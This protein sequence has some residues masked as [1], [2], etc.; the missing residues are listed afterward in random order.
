MV[1]RTQN[2]GKNGPSF[3]SVTSA[4]ALRDTSSLRQATILNDRP[5]LGTGDYQNGTIEFIQLT[6][7]NTTVKSKYWLQ[8]FDRFKGQT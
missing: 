6:S 1:K 8:I 3:Y 7:F 2:T 4:L 5:Q